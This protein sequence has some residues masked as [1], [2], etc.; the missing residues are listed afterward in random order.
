MTYQAPN[1][2]QVPNLLLDEHMRD[3]SEAELRI[4]L[5][6]CRKT[7]GWH[8]QKDRISLTQ[9]EELTGMSRQG[10]IGGV[11]KAIG[12][13][14][15]ERFERGQGFEYSLVIEEVVN[16]VDYQLV[17]V[18]DTQK[19]LL[20]KKTTATQDFLTASLL[21]EPN[22]FDDYPV[23]VASLLRVFNAEF[24]NIKV[25]SKSKWIKQARVWVAMGLSEK[26]IETMCKYVKKQDGWMVAQ[27]ASITSAY[28]VI[29]NLP[30]PEVP[31]KVY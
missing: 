30:K 11:Q 24:P 16:E 2:T 29:Q 13:G 14:L 26:T 3:M 6:V 18:V 15:L 8:K 23:D 28:N 4:M 5:A 25:D 9:L 21:K 17:N 10:V 19:K 20:Q 1:H 27:P 31:V 12:R 7:F 22:L